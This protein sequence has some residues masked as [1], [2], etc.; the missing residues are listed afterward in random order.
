MKRTTF[1]GLTQLEPGDGLFDDNQGF[2]DRNVAVVARVL[3]YLLSSPRDGHEA[4]DNP[5]TAPT[6]GLADAGG[7]LPAGSPFSAVFTAVDA[8]GGETLPSP[9]VT[10]ETPTTLADVPGPPTGVADYG[11]GT[12]PANS[13]YYVLTALDAAGGESE[14][15]DPLL[16]NVD[17]GNVNARV[18]LDGL[19]TAA[20]AAGGVS[21]RLYRA[22]NGGQLGLLGQDSTETFTDDGSPCLDPQ[23][24]PPV[25][26]TGGGTALA[27]VT[28]PVALIPEGAVALRL[29]A[30]PDPAFPSP[31][32]VSEQAVVAGTPE[33]VWSVETFGLESGSPPPASTSLPA[34][35]G[36][37][38]GGG[39]GGMLTPLPPDATARGDSGQS[40]TAAEMDAASISW[41]LSG[42]HKAALLAR[43]IDRDDGT[44][45]YSTE[46]AWSADGTA[47][48]PVDWRGATSEFNWEAGVGLHTIGGT[49]VDNLEY[50]V[51]AGAGYGD[52]GWQA[53]FIIDDAAGWDRLFVGGLLY[54]APNDEGFAVILDRALASLRLVHI[55]DHA[56]L[57][58][59]VLAS[60]AVALP[61]VGDT[62]ELAVRRID[63]TIYGFAKIAGQP[64]LDA[65]LT[66]SL[67]GTGISMASLSGN[68]A[69]G[70]FGANWNTVDALRVWNVEIGYF[71]LQ[72][73]EL[74][75]GPASDGWA[76][77]SG[78]PTWGL[79][80]ATVVWSSE[81]ETRRVGGSVLAD[82]SLDNY[83]GGMQGVVKTSTGHYTVT[84][85]PMPQTPIVHVD[86]GLAGHEVS[87]V[88]NTG[89]DVHTV[90]GTGTDADAPFTFVAEVA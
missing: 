23:L 83:F 82:G 3:Q 1:L 60:A 42:R 76:T 28:V 67:A 36:G 18:L 16:V 73:L 11:G 8:Y 72:V 90:D 69:L 53:G 31:S 12:L 20:E 6:L 87:A 5:D 21:W 25:A 46:I 88:T 32:F 41:G 54:S 48:D 38:G 43:Y 77:S 10:D 63:D 57:T 80:D 65:P 81:P 2:T 33:Y 61:A 79:D 86:S 78:E 47:Y 24:Q 50:R 52:G 4:L 35:V 27:T 89:F 14:A 70:M 29:Y 26:S 51:A 22:T 40:P 75:A 45:V 64:V 19:Q 56:P 17:P 66:A 49:G 13:Y 34:V 30:S 15:S 59:T 44:G 37:G 55:T 85:N 62:V 7:S 71:P 74:V 68:A 84:Y 9:V 58:Y 39:A